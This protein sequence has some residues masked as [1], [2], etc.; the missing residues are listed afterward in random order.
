MVK[1]KFSPEDSLSGWSLKEWFARNKLWFI[2]N[3][4]TFKALVSGGCG[5]LAST[6]ST[7]LEISLLFGVGGAFG[8]KLIVDTIDFYVN[9]VELK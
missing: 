4:N 1:L 6:Y 3:K 5:I 8:T 9:K 2:K 7:N